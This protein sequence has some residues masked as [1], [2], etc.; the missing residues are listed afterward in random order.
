MATSDL[1]LKPK[2]ALSPSE[3]ADAG[4][5]VGEANWNQLEADWRIFLDL[6]RVYAAHTDA[7]LVAGDYRRRGLAT[8]LMRR[9]M[10]DL[11]AAGLVA[12]L[13]ATPDGRAVYRA[14]GFQDS[15]GFHRLVLRERPR[16]GEIPAAPAG[17]RPSP[18]TCSRT[19]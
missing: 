5:L 6:G 19:V 17:A 14:L 11:A 3:L 13:D 1:P 4:A 12:V 7:V 15:W 16:E 9:A 10:D 8:R 18:P 2:S